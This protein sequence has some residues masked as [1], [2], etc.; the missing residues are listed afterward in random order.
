MKITGMCSV[1][2]CLR[3]EQPVSGSEQGGSQL[4]RN[5][6]NF[7]ILCCVCSQLGAGQGKTSL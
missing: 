7:F 3:V 5:L 6:A 2:L 1:L 4:M